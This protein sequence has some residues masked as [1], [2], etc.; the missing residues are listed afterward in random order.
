MENWRDIPG[1]E[2]LYQ[3]STL[4]RIRTCEGKVT[5]RADGQRRVWKQR[6]LKPKYELRKRANGKADAR[7][8]LWKDGEV[9]TL[10]VARLVALTWCDGYTDDMTVNHIDG[11]TLN[12][13]AAN[14]EWV[15]Q[16]DN[17]RLAFKSGFIHTQKPVRLI[18]KDGV[19]HDFCSMTEACKFMNRN[20]GYISNLIKRG[21]SG[22]SGY[23]IQIL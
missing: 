13:S 12:N 9:K 16:G 10:L 4:G 20:H 17:N 15:T 11:D 18:S 8:N 7:V 1:Y 2:H 22:K 6:I 3:A 21:Y 14:L 19:T 5:V 23:T